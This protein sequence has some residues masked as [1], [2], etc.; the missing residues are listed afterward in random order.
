MKRILTILFCICLIGIFYYFYNN[1]EG[2]IMK[3]LYYTPTV[4][5][6]EPNKYSRKRDYDFVSITDDFIPYGYQDLLDI[7]YTVLDY[8]Y[9]EFTFYCPKEYYDCINDIEYLSSNKTTDVLTTIG[10]LVHPYNNFDNIKVKYDTTGKVTLI[11]EHLYT[12]E[13]I[14]KIEKELDNI[15]HNNLT[16]DA[17]QSKIIRFFHDY[18]IDTTTYDFEYEKQL[19]TVV[20]V[21]DDSAKAT[22]VLFNRNA[23][24]SGYTDTM[25]IILDRLGIY[26]F[27][28][29]SDSHVW[30]VLRDNGKL[31]HLDVTWDDPTVV[32]GDQTYETLSYKYYLISNDDLS[33]MDNDSHKFNKSIYTEIK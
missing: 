18:I 30:N 33:R 6:K 19:K 9:D 32:D 22:G 20:G 21:N 26:N 13:E 27:K 16:A 24:C 4:E 2:F 31:V 1:I 11:V 23:I 5:V 8:G 17:N 14:D 25:A 29:T 12:K 7:V 3:A 28:V 10:N 15:W